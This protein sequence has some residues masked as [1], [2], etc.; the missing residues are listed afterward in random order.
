MAGLTIDH[1]QIAIPVD[2]EIS[3]RGYYADIVG[4]IE[5]PKPA[6]LALRGG[7]WFQTGDMQFHLGIDK[8][9]HPAQ[10]AHVALRTNQF[11]ALR[12]RIEAAG[13]KIVDAN[14]ID[15]CRRFFSNDPF[16]NRIE[17]ISTT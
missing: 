12:S 5:L 13:Y 7:C 3:A 6:D 9:F 8:D 10:K 14:D 16:G 11:E 2:G 4:L 17:F 1:V 15:G